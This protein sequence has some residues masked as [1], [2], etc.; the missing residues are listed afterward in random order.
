MGCGPIL[1]AGRAPSVRPSQQTNSARARLDSSRLTNTLQV[2]DPPEWENLLLKYI[3]AKLGETLRDELKVNPRKQDM[4]APKWLDTLH[5][6]LTAPNA[7]FED[8]AQW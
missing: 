2:F 6:W 3:V 1:G 5:K 7:S 4:D 8:I